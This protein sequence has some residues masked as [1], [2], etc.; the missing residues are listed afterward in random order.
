[1]CT[2]LA[3]PQLLKSPFT[4]YLTVGKESKCPGRR[5][6][7]VGSGKCLVDGTNV[8]GR[9]KGSI[10]SGPGDG[11]SEADN[12]SDPAA[13]EI[14]ETPGHKETLTVP[15]HFIKQNEATE[16]NAVSHG[17]AEH[18]RNGSVVYRMRKNCYTDQHSVEGKLPSVK[19]INALL[20][21]VSRSWRERAAAI[22]AAKAELASGRP[23]S[24][25]PSPKDLGAGSR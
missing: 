14:L 10:G 19:R 24:A 21:T 3:R 11:V 2:R 25:G 12:S 16:F 22:R 4:E 17:N 20:G 15:G 7:K 23:D 1:M 6:A 13:F 5:A 8:S 9:D 18:V